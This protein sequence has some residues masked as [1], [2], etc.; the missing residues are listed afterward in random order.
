LRVAKTDGAALTI[1]I[2]GGLLRVMRQRRLTAGL[3]GGLETHL[4]F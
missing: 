3:A 4:D 1:R 2:K